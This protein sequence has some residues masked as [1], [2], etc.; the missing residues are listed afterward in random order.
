MSFIL[1]QFLNCSVHVDRCYNY[2]INSFYKTFDKLVVLTILHD[3]DKPS[4]KTYNCILIPF[5]YFT[6]DKGIYQL[7]LSFSIEY[8]KYNFFQ[9]LII[10]NNQMNWYVSKNPIRKISSDFTKIHYLN[11]Q[12]NSVFLKN[13]SSF[14]TDFK[15]SADHFCSI[16][17]Q[18]IGSEVVAL[19]PDLDEITFKDIDI[20]E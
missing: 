19:T 5:L 10:Y 12:I 6:V 14:Y 2:L 17:K 18:E 3:I 20:I 15:L 13:I 1:N 11:I 16:M 7:D 9:S 4:L 8:S